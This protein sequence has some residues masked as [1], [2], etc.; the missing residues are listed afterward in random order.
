MNGSSRVQLRA[1]EAWPQAAPS[2]RSQGEQTALLGESKRAW[3]LGKRRI[4]N[5]LSGQEKGAG[6]TTVTH[7][8][9]EVP[10]DRGLARTGQHAQYNREGV[11][12][13]QTGPAGG[14]PRELLSSQFLLF[15]VFQIFQSECAVWEDGGNYGEGRGFALVSVLGIGTTVEMQRTCHMACSQP[16]C[17]GSQRSR[18]Q[19]RRVPGSP[20]Q[21][22]AAAP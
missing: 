22:G 7:T 11:S 12:T 21:F 19:D 16:K 14:T 8:L 10:W 20:A 6:F 1:A 5:T 4:G 13:Q 9:S 2:G 15:Y 3:T 18:G 17:S